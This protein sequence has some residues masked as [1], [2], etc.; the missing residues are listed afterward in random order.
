MKIMYG[1]SI[2]L[3]GESGFA[4]G[5][6]HVC[7]GRP[8]VTR[9]LVPLSLTRKHTDGPVR[10]Q[11]R[12]ACVQYIRNDRPRGGHLALANACSTEEPCEPYEGLVSCAPR[13]VGRA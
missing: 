2:Y 3:P 9:Y 1:R 11:P 6:A 7:A 8:A 5:V 4:Y 12:G 13:G 10:A